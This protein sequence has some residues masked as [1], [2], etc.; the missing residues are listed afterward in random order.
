MGCGRNRAHQP[1]VAAGTPGAAS[2]PACL[3]GGSGGAPAGCVRRLQ[4]L[5]HRLVHHKGD[6]GLGHDPQHVW[7]Q[8]SVK[9]GQP[10]P[11]QCLPDGVRHAAVLHCSRAVHPLL[12]PGADHLVVGWGTIGGPVVGNRASMSPREGR[13]EGEHVHDAACG[14]LTA[15]PNRGAATASHPALQAQRVRPC[16]PTQSVLAAKLPLEQASAARRPTCDGYVATEATILDRAP[17]AMAS[18]GDSGVAA[19]LAVGLNRRM[20]GREGEPPL[21][22]RS[23]RHRVL[24]SVFSSSYT[25]NWMAPCETWRSRGAG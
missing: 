4:P 16:A 13:V 10:L 24:T 2:T 15:G 6:G 23:R 9:P 22:E 19:S 21:S 12:Q 18:S 7:H 25:A 5:H 3:G 14:C 1:G 8:A 11:P 20:A 17:Q